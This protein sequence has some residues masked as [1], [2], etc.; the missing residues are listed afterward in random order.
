[1]SVQRFFAPCPRGL[2]AL[3]ATELGELGAEAAVPTDGGVAFSGEEQLLYRTNLECRLASRILLYVGSCGYRNEEEIYRGA[4]AV[5]WPALFER[6]RTIRIA[7]SAVHSPLRSLDFVTLRVKD[8]VCDAFRA[9]TGERPNVDTRSPDVRI[10]VFL[11]ARTA[12]FYLDTSGE[13]LFKRGWRTSDVDAPLRENLAAGILRVAGWRPGVPLLDPMCGGGTFLLEAA[14]AS[15]NIPPGAHRGFGFERLARYDPATWRRVREA[16]D[17]KRQRIA[18]LPLFGSD[19]DPRAISASR[20]ALH[21]A[22][23]DNVAEL[24]RADILAID[25]PAAEGIMVF[26]P[27][28][29]VR[30]GEQAA[31]AELYP[32]LG[33]RLKQ[34][35]AGWR[36]FIFTADTRLPKLIGLRPARRTPLY[37]GALECRLYEFAIVSG[38][39]RAR[40]EPQDGG[41]AA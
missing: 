7:V 3:L 12:T 18:R 4:L 16:A 41:P 23:L 5:P 36:C 21:R 13:P 15:L 37:N 28:Y 9:A 34:R 40:R 29:G 8:A 31:L 1:M 38:S 35:F 2:E 33:D 10:H 6:T 20:K 30:I 24:V 25:P 39:M 14:S 11:D 32:K 26:N 19:R 22:G 17:E 27:P